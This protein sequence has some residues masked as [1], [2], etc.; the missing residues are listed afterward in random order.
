MSAEDLT[1]VD[2]LFVY[3][4]FGTPREVREWQR[5]PSSYHLAVTGLVENELRLSLD[6]LRREFEVASAP[7]IIQCMT[8]VHWGQIEFAGARLTDVLEKA[9]VSSQA[10][11][12]ALK[13]ADGFQSNLKLEYLST[14]EDP[15]LAAYKMNGEP[16]P[17]DHGFPVRIASPDKYGYKWPKWVV[18]IEA[19]DHDPGGHYETKRGWSDDAERGRP[20]T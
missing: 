4:I 11:R 1:P 19:V 12:V 18:E 3:H 20:V 10:T 2:D 6:D 8:N 7:M 14:S 17:I 9:G 16:I 15:V 13:S 5:D